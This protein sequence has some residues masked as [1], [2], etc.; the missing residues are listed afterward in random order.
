MEN[1]P[2]ITP[3]QVPT[4][5]PRGVSPVRWWLFIVGMVPGIALA[6]IGYLALQQPNLEIGAVYY[7][8]FFYLLVP[9]VLV[10]IGIVVL[11][12][13]AVM[14]KRLTLGLGIVLGGLLNL[15]MGFLAK[16]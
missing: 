4:R 6:A 16:P 3:P 14:K 2:T 13:A 11:L 10:V 1:E 5:P 12:V 7:A 8:V 15:L 9:D